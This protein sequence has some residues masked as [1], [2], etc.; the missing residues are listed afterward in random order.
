MLIFQT[1]YLKTHYP[2][3]YMAALMTSEADDTEK[4]GSLIDECRSKGI[5][6]LPPDV[7]AS[8]LRTSVEDGK[9]V[10]GLGAIKG[11]GQGAIE[12]ILE[13]RESS[14]FTD[15]Y[16]FCE[17]ISNKKITKKVVESLIKCGAMDKSGGAS[18]E[19]LLEVLPQ[20]MEKREKPKKNKPTVS[21]LTGLAPPP[22]IVGAPTQRFWPEVKPMSQEDRLAF[23]KDLLGFYVSGHP[24]LPYV[25]VMD[26]IKTHT[27][28]KAKKLPNQTKVTVCGQLSNISVRVS[29]RGN[30]FATGKVSDITDSCEIVFFDSLIKKKGDILVDGAVLALSGKVSGN[31][32][33]EKGRPKIQ[34][35]SAA[36][37]DGSLSKVFH[38]VTVETSLKDLDPVIDFFIGRV[39]PRN[40]PS[41]KLSK[42]VLNISD[43]NG[44]AEY[45]LN[46]QVELSVEFFKEA[47]NSL[48]PRNLIRC[49]PFH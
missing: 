24:L 34:V 27:L 5:E 32:W 42:V 31:D 4:I 1:A 17:R 38:A 36:E 15:L 13:A 22:R 33:N 23:E 39:E 45:E 25:S 2:I 43:G 16:D 8:S 49:S 40:S 10:F 29:K 21:L 7:N 14:P 47:A 26:A 30:K 48:G 9:I 19:V 41:K 44:R 28:T 6:V 11:I 3:E 20:A 18:R 35:E 46:D 12:A 37:L